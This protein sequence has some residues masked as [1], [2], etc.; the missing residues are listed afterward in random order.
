[1]VNAWVPPSMEIPSYVMYKTMNLPSGQSKKIY[2]DHSA[3]P[4]RWRVPKLKCITCPWLKGKEKNERIDLEW[5]SAVSHLCRTN[6]S[7]NTPKYCP[8]L[9]ITLQMLILNPVIYSHDTYS[10][11]TESC[12][13]NHSAV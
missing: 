8:F 13:S 1:M 7:T 5:T 11:G 3:Q 9:K 10:L 2:S 12:R 6:N 4:N